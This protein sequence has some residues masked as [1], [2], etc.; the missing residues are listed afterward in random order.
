M[1]SYFQI[2]YGLIHSLCIAEEYP[3]HQQFAQR[4]NVVFK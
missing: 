3:V 2:I 1:Q 4:A